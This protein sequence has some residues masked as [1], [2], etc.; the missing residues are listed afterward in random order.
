MRQD[1]R[2]V[3]QT[4]V[5]G[6][7]PRAF[8]SRARAFLA[9]QPARNSVI[10]TNLERALAGAAPA[11]ESHLWWW[12]EQVPAGG[13]EPR[14]V[15]ALMQTPPHGAYLAGD[16]PEALRHLAR[17]LYA[18]RP[19]LPSVG[20]PDGAAPVFAE[21][22]ARCGGPVA[23]LSMRQRM[24]VADSLV[25]PPPVA[26]RHRLAVQEDVPLLGPWGEA[27]VDEATPGGLRVD[28]VGPRVAAG[29]LHVWEVDGRPVSMA[30]ITLPQAGVSRV[31]LVY[32][33]PALRGRGYAA[34]CV[35]A[36]TR[37]ELAHPGRRCMLYTD[38]TNPTSNALYERLGYRRIGEALDLVLEPEPPGG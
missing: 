24:L 9:E 8:A 1:R 32:T 14:V 7:D 6:R 30:A 34:A 4:V 22:W 26:G 11:P 38:A 28:H 2:M 10:L 25:E 37:G 3:G 33:P 35:A 29:L 13:G 19:E 27:F 15:A 23:R 18:V 17:R 5:T 20:G 31:Q 36:V 21:E 12:V 16:E